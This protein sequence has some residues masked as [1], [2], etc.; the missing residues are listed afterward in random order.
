MNNDNHQIEKCQTVFNQD[1]SEDLE[2]DNRYVVL[3]MKN[4]PTKNR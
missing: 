3:E 4:T 2:H 1:S